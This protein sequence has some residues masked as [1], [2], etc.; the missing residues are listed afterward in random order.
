MYQEFSDYIRSCEKCQRVKQEP[1]ASSLP[2]NPLPVVGPFERLHMDLIGPL[3][4]SDEGHSYILVCVLHDEIFCRYGASKTIVTDRG[5]NF[6]SKLVNAICEIYQVAL[7]KTASYHPQANCCVERQNATISKT[8]AKYIRK[9]QR[10]WHRVLPVV[11]MGM[12]AHP[13]TETSAFSPF[14]M[15][16]GAEMRLPFDTN[17]IPRDTLKP[18]DK[19]IVRELLDTLNLIHCTA[20]ANT[21][22]TQ[23]DS[24]LRH[25]LKAKDSE[26][27]ILENVL[28]RVHK[29]T[30]GL[31]QKLEEKWDGPYYTAAKGPNNTID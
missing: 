20:K 13:N 22:Q 27:R 4:K 26:Y 2:L 18:E 11:L 28:R 16:F 10:N 7:H 21:E 9:D 8:I 30:P 31:S 14:K 23:N 6:L 5:R 17:L 29:H 15:L 1:N 19:I 24:K 3:T 25:D 12:R